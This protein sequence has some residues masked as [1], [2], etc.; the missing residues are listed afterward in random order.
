MNAS[1]EH[2][3]W[4]IAF[5][6]DLGNDHDFLGQIFKQLYLMNGRVDCCDIQRK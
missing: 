1:I 2:Q 6:C 5:S 4:N 3:A